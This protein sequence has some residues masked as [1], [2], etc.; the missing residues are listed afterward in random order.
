MYHRARAV[1]DGAALRPPGLA[2][3]PERRLQRRA[4]GRGALLLS[5]PG[6]LVA[7]RNINKPKPK[8]AHVN[9]CVIPIRLGRGAARAEPAYA[10]RMA[11]DAP[12]A[13]VTSNGNRAAGDSGWRW[14]MYAWL[15]P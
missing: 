3:A 4:A 9:V 13:L 6:V 12:A 15:N 1:L 11:M 2:A 10:L 8:H 7:P 5:S 14:L